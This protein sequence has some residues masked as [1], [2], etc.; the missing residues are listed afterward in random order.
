MKQE[1]YF[2]ERLSFLYFF[3]VLE[4]LYIRIKHIGAEF[5]PFFHLHLREIT[6][7]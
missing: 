7:Q 1:K 6:A 3:F 5:A 4:M 2:L